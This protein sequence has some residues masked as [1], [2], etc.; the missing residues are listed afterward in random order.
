M[1][2]KLCACM[3]AMAIAWTATPHWARSQ[4]PKPALDITGTVIDAETK[5]P[6]DRAYVL[7]S[8]K[9]VRSGLATTK[10]FCVKTLGM[11]TGPDGKYRF[12]VERLDGVSPLSTNAI[13]PGYYLDRFDIPD[14][15]TWRRQGPDLYANRNIYLKKQ[16]PAHPIFRFG[17]TEEN[18]D[19]AAN[20]DALAPALRF[21][22]TELAEEKR[23][24]ASK[25]GIE[26]HE[27]LIRSLQHLPADLRRH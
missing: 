23:L 6:I 14:L 18:C 11:Y 21:I 7:A 4:P 24:G 8:Y 2:T 12:P 10:S 19:E 16:D 13:K 17:D 5:Q 20:A 9:V 15:A 22:E 27:D 1:R 26:A 3:T 25:Q